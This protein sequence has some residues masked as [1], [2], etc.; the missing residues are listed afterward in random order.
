MN[1]LQLS[2]IK[3]IKTPSFWLLVIAA[4]L[5]AINLTLF[6]KMGNV[7]HAGMSALFLLAIGSMLWDKRHNLELESNLSATLLGT[8]L[9]TWVLFISSSMPETKEDPLLSVAPFVSGVGVSLIAS[10]FRGLKQFRPELIIVFFLG[11]PRVLIE[12]VV[13]IS[14]VTAKVSSFILHYLGFQVFLREGIYIHLPQGAVKVFYGCSGMES[15]TYVL[16]LS[17]VCLIMFPIKKSDR[18]F[19]P[20]VAIIT[21]FLVNACRVA[22][23]AILSNEGQQESFIYWHEGEGSLIFGMIA[24]AIF[25]LFYWFLIN[26]ADATERNEEEE[27]IYF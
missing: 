3:S 13:D 22:L 27:K 25:G 20:I 8:L 15:M 18:F 7:A 26:R 12:S 6:W 16:G 19:V 10:G 17:V 1:T 21:G 2:T 14:P 11:V 24:V 4:G 9:I 5:V 23:L